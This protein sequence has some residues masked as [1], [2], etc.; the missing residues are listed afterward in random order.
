VL[1]GSKDFIAKAWRWK[2]LFGG[3]MRQS[4]ILAAAGLYALD[5]HVDRLREDH[6]NAKFFATELS[7]IPGIELDTPNPQTNIV[8]F[9]VTSKRMTGAEFL[10]RALE[11]GVRFSGLAT[12]LRAVTH[13]DIK[14]SDIETALKVVRDLL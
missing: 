6:D 3:A 7:K 2:H 13:L 9:R 12:G 4:G 10:S 11:K 1:A 8:F 14:R 5:R